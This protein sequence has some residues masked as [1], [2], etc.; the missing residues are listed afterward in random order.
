MLTSNLSGGWKQRLA[1]GCAI[2]HQPKV[3]FLD[4][5]TAGVDPISRRE[6]WGLIY[7]MARNGRHGA[8]DHPLHGRG[9]AVPAGRV[10]QPGPAGGARY[11]RGAQADPDARPGAGDQHGRV[12]RAMRV[13]EGCPGERPGCRSTKSPCT[14]PRSMPW[15]PPPSAIASRFAMLLRAEDGIVVHSIE[16]IAPTLEDVF[17][18]TVKPRL[19]KAEVYHQSA[20][21]AVVKNNT[22]KEFPHEQPAP[23]FNPSSDHPLPVPGGVRRVAGRK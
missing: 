3:V 6:F 12:D 5:P 9:R 18:S 4:E 21:V 22:R 14:A 16:W 10:Y 15:C 2:V 7:A 17:I 1:L 23:D 20:F 13:S 19:M 11:A 8:G